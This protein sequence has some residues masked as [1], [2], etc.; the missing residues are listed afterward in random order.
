LQTIFAIFAV[1]QFDFGADEVVIRRK[2]IE[3]SNR[4]LLYGLLQFTFA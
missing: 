4:G 1:E 3:M 2:Y